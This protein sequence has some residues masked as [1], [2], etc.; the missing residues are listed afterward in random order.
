MGIVW[1]EFSVSVVVVDVEVDVEAILGFFY[2]LDRT[3]AS[4]KGVE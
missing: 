2:T 3:E 4:Y 1:V